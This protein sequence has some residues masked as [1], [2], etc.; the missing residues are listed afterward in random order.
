MQCSVKPL[1]LV[2]QVRAVPVW[3]DDPLVQR[4]LAAQYLGNREDEVGKVGG[5]RGRGGGPWGLFRVWQKGCQRQGR[6]N[7]GR[8]K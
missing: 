4:C 3:I 2:L 1:C 7:T 5:K 6:R 8:M